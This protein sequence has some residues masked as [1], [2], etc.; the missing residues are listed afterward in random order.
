MTTYGYAC[1]SQTLD[2]QI[3]ALTAAGCGGLRR[4]RAFTDPGPELATDVHALWPE[5]YGSA[6]TRSS[7]P[8]R[9]LR[10]YG[11]ATPVKWL[12]SAE[13]TTSHIRRYLGSTLRPSG[14]V[15]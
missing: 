4:V 1:V 10:L 5:G 2:A 11:A 14:S 7:Q 3:A 12:K 9:L 15:L 13:A 8:I 6:G